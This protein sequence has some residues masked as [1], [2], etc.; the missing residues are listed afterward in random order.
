MKVKS[1]FLGVAFL[2]LLLA[3]HARA[4][5]RFIVRVGGG[6]TGI[7]QICTALGCTVTRGLDG[8]LGQLFLV[9]V[10]DAVDPDL[11]L[12]LL[13]IQSGVSNVELDIPINLL[14]ISGSNTVPSGLSDSSPLDYFGRTVWNG[15]A[16][17]PASQVIGLN[18]ARMKFNVFGSGIVGV[19]D[20][21]IDP[22]HPA[23]QGAVVIG[24]DFTRNIR[25]IPSESSDLTQP[26]SPTVTGQPPARVNESTSAVVDHDSAVVLSQY[27]AFGHGTMVSGVIHLVAPNTLIMP[28]K[29]FRAD[30]T[31]SMSDVIRAVYYGTQNGAKILN[32]SFSTPNYSKEL[33]RAL[34]NAAANRVIS[35]GSAGN[36]G[37]QI[38][39]YP[40]AIDD[41]MGVAST[42][43]TDQRSSFS[44]YG[45]VVWVAAPGEAIISTYPFGTYAASSGTSFSAPF[46]SGVAA[47]LLDIRSASSQKE[48]ASAISN[49]RKLG[50]ELGYGRLDVYEAVQALI[51]APSVTLIFIRESI[52]SVRA[53]PYGVGANKSSG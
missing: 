39:V 44:N 38:L 42:D 8:T 36:D 33:A 30:G 46:V 10:P 22:S 27:A 15:Y 14:P 45:S 47:L 43:Y 25:G 35:V 7:Q 53:H 2:F 29:A 50:P 4:E 9:G 13:Q 17:Q 31:G 41:V 37:K 3:Q 1:R 26:V 34:N 12:L 5:H 19:I 6:L 18:A 48:A 49:A 21:G 24:Y 16:N 23:L 32:M 28:L 51:N 11:F 20:T 52:F 40:A